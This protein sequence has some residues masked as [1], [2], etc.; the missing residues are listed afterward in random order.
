MNGVGDHIGEI[1]QFEGTFMRN[2][3]AGIAERKPGS[4][5]MFLGAGGEM[6]QA[7]KATPNSFVATTGTG[8]MAQSAAVHTGINGLPG[9]EVTS[10][11]LG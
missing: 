1:K 10:L 3:C 11:R 7:E 5:Y 6:T 4:H 9:S 2:N 8:V